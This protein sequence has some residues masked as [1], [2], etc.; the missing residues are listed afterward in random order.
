MKRFRYGLIPLMIAATFGPAVVRA[1]DTSA[2]DDRRVYIAPMGTYT[3]ADKARGTDNGIGGEM[4][5]GKRFTR[6]LELELLGSYTGYS[7]KQGDFST[8]Q[9]KG[10]RVYGAGAGANVFLAPSADW[11]IHGLFLHV[12]V[13]RGQGLDQPGP[14]NS[15]T[16]TLFNAGFGYD[17]P[18]HLTFGGL[19]A[20]GMAIRTEALYHLD[21]HNRDVIGTNTTGGQKDFTEAQ[22]NIG[23]HIPLGGRSSPAAPPPPEP[24]TEVVPAPEPPAAPPPPPPPPPC[25]PPAPGQP[26]SL[27]GCKTGDVL[28]LHGVNFDFNK[29]SLTLNAKALL[30]QVADALLA[31]KD[32]KV[33]IDGHTDGKGSGPYNM[34][35]SQR[36]ADSVKQYLVGRGVDADRMTTKGFGKTMPIADNSTDEGREQ[37]R[38]VE[39]KVTESNGGAAAAPAE[40]PAAAP[41]EAPAPAP[42]EA[43]APAPADN[44]APAPAPAPS[45]SGSAPAPAPADSGSAPAPAP[46]DSGSSSG[47]SSDSSAPA[48]APAPQ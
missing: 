27:E 36:R 30:D 18:L 2:A 14:V 28:V 21:S 13:M 7:T 43:P 1:D 25:Q 46:A 38:R 34:K 37:N 11:F 31:R 9:P 40:A 3:L 10:A 47:G 12:D 39:L 44:S 16:S 29:A 22:F 35:L 6:G 24:P 45:D 17:F 8:P 23:L 19:F 15:Y 4:A 20:P 42:A 41:A 33:E 32:I 26:I 5:V 48:P